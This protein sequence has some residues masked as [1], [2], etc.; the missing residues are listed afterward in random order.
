MVLTFEYTQTA[1]RARPAPRRTEGNEGKTITKYLVSGSGS[2]TLD[3]SEPVPLEGQTN[4]V[5]TQVFSVRA[6]GDQG[7]STQKLAVDVKISRPSTGSQA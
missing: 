4:A 5:G 1:A 6:Q 7:T 2:T 3:L